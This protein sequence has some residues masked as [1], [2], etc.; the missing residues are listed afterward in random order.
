MSKKA[1]S[2]GRKMPVG[3]IVRVRVAAL[4]GDG[5]DRLD[6]V[7]A[8][9]VEH[10]VRLGDDVVLADA[11]LQLLVDHV[12]GAVDHGRGLVQQ[13]DLVDVLDLAR[14]EH[15][16]LA[17]DDL[18]AGLLQL[19]EHRRLGEV[20]ADRHVGDAGVAQE[21]H[22]LVRVALHQADRRRHR[23]AHAEHARRARCPAR[24]SRNRG[25]GGRRPS[26]SPRRSA[27]CSRISSAKRQSLSRSHSPILVAVT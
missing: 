7:R 3:E 1:W 27:P 14:V 17:V 12:I 6:V 18:H 4:A 5:V 19:E 11:R 16:L 10:L 13:H 23:A 26:R 21:R 25:G 8:E 24:A 2:P 9:P 15:D 22:D 20:D